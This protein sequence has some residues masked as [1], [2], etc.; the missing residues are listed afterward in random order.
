MF[1]SSDTYYAMMTSPLRNYV[2]CNIQ[3]VINVK[4]LLFEYNEEEE[5]D[6]EDEEEEEDKK[7][8]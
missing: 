8:Q 1:I 4:K 3:Y 6:E 2:V 7:D 5:K